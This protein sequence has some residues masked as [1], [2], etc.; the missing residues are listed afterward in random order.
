M[1]G[2]LLL[3]FYERHT[4]KQRDGETRVSRVGLQPWV[5]KRKFS[6]REEE[7]ANLLSPSGGHMI[8][9]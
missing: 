6:E 8:E 3:S 5:T 7:V 9:T 1:N 4:Y 2:R